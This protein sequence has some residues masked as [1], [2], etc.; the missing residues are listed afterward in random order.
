MAAIRSLSGVKRKLDFEPAK[1][2]FWRKAAIRQNC[3]DGVMWQNGEGSMRQA[4]V[5]SANPR[6]PSDK[7][8][9]KPSLCATVT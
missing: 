8:D 3:D 7:R 6:Q 9:A 1:G 2:S 4:Y 5:W